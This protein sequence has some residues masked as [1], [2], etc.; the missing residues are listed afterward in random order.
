MKVRASFVTVASSAVVFL[1]SA[2]THSGMY[3]VHAD[4]LARYEAIT[5]Y[6]EKADPG[7]AAEYASRLASLTDGHSGDELANARNSAKYRNALSQAGAT[8][9]AAST[10]TAINGCTEFLADQ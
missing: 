5:S 3:S 8:L 4:S 1:V 6:C 9:A 10:A 2:Y 7:S